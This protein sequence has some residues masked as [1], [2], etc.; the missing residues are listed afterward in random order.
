MAAL[1]LKKKDIDPEGRGLKV[2]DVLKEARS[3]HNELVD[4]LNSINSV[5]SDLKEKLEAHPGLA[6]AIEFNAQSIDNIKVTLMPE[7]KRKMDSDLTKVK[8]DLAV[9]VHNNE[10]QIVDLE[11]HSRRKN[12]VINGKVKKKDEKVEEVARQFFVND[13]KME[14]E[15]VN[16]FL[17][18]DCHRLPKPKPKNDGTQFPEPIIVAF[19]LQKDRNSVMRKAYEIKGTTL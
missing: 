6:E 18:R 1:N 10:K 8:T 12:V 9:E 16:K 4:A 14:E 7:L 17:F 11:G 13:L 15:E 2:I 5:L 3:N 19:V